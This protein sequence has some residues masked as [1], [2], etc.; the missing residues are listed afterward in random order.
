MS[1]FNNVALHAL[2]T[3]MPAIL[4][5]PVQNVTSSKVASSHISK[6]HVIPPCS[7]FPFDLWSVP[8]V[9]TQNLV[10]CSI[11]FAYILSPSPRRM[12]NS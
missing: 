1:G 4:Q 3:R 7:D 2:F 6:H 9:W 8:I 11:S 12:C 10:L 5:D